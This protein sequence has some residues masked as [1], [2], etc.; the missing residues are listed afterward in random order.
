[1]LNQA[2]QCIMECL[3]SISILLNSDEKI[4]F[5]AIYNEM[6]LKGTEHGLGFLSTVEPVEGVIAA[7]RACKK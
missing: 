3:D 7:L 2:E 5:Q 6:S 1:M 4:D